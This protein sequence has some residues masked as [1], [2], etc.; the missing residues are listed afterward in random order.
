MASHPHLI[1]HYKSRS[2]RLFSSLHS[3]A[4]RHGRALE[5]A[6]VPS[7]GREETHAAPYASCCSDLPLRGRACVIEGPQVPRTMDTLNIQRYGSHSSE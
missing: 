7:S 6:P 5:E 2:H 4:A 1:H 3:A